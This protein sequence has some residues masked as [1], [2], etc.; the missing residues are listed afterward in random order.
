M[1]QVCL[2][3]LL[4]SLSVFADDSQP[5]PIT[6]ADPVRGHWSVES[7]NCSSGAPARDAFIVG[8]DEMNLSFFDGR[9]DAYT[10]IGLCNYWTTGHYQV[11]NNML[12]VFDAVGGSN[13]TN[14]PVPRE[15]SVL[16]STDAA[17]KLHIYSGPFGAGGT[18]PRT[19]ILD[20]TFK[21]F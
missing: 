21:G 12:R 19:D 8:R 3:V 10:R 7:R 6:P 17:G 20:S 16:F 5:Q 4:F 2:S 9:Y 15:A 11:T 13:C 18:C 1:I 14:Q